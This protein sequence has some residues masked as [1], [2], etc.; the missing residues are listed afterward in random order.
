[1]FAWYW[2]WWEVCWQLDIGS[3]EWWTMWPDV[4][5][6]FFSRFS[7]NLTMNIQ[8]CLILSF[9]HNVPII[10][11]LTILKN[12][13][14]PPCHPSEKRFPLRPHKVNYLFLRQRPQLSNGPAHCILFYQLGK[15]AKWFPHW[16]Y[17][18][19]KMTKWTAAAK[20]Y[21]THNGFRREHLVW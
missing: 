3:S 17:S 13:Y 6:H 12:S 18:Q 10:L 1:M 7:S 5:W 4:C 15:M 9:D 19:N 14:L 8:Q 21:Q 20:F 2:Q 16:L 11:S